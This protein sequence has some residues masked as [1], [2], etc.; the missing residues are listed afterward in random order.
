MKVGFAGLDAMGSRMARNS[1]ERDLLA[2]AWNR[3]IEKALNFAAATGCT[4]AESPTAL[5]AQCN[6]VLICI[7]A[8]PEVLA[9]VEQGHGDKDV[10]ASR[11][12]DALFQNSR[13]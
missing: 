13:S 7:S 5:A 8:D 9:I 2:C 10:A 4:L 12:K 11:L 6:I 3:T 1:H